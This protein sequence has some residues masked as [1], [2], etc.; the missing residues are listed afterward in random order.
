MSDNTGNMSRLKMW[1]IK[2]KVCPKN[3][4]SV[5]V[6]KL[7]ESGNLVCNSLQLQQLYIRVYK[8][9]L[10]HRTIL[11]EY[12]QMKEHK[13][14]LFSLRLKLLKT[15]KTPEW[16]YSDINQVMKKLKTNKATD[17]VGLVGELFKPGIAGTDVVK[18]MQYDKE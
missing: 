9:R 6:A 11:P 14:Y 10:R 13:E 17:L 18:T 3:S 16:N 15:R 5:P 7:D 12:R 4:S 1:K 8:D 2:S